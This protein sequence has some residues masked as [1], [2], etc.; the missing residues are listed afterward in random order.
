MD[1]WFWKGHKSLKIRAYKMGL[2]NI[3][4]IIV[5]QTI[6]VVTCTL[7]TN[8]QCN[9]IAVQTFA[10]RSFL[11]NVTRNSPTGIESYKHNVQSM[12]KIVVIANI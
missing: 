12:L 3:Q 9:H 5:K 8:Y 2:K 4:Y 6:D 7:F 1:R 10:A 11:F